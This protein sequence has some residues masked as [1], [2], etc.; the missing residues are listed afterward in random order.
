MKFIFYTREFFF[1]HGL[2]SALSSGPCSQCC[3]KIIFCLYMC[4]QIFLKIVADLHH[5]DADPVPDLSFTFM[6][7]S[8]WLSSLMRFRIRLFVVTR[9]RI[10][11]KGMRI[12]DHWSTDTPRL[13]FWAFTPPSGLLNWLQ[14]GSRSWFWCGSG[15]FLK[16][17]R[18]KIFKR[19]MCY[20]VL[21]VLWKV[22]NV[23]DMLQ[24]W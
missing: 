1:S 4:K 3:I 13:H 22:M 17:E 8:I 7:I 19:G 11:I 18:R 5:F 12:W 15:A 20:L 24:D 2:R 9:I 14:C 23:G 10:L 21:N 16:V 6:H